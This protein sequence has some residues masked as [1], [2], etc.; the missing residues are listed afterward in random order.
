MKISGLPVDTLR[1]H[2]EDGYGLQELAYE[3]NSENMTEVLAGLRHRFGTPVGATIEVNRSYPQQQ[4]VWHA[5][6]DVITAVKSEV[7]PFLLYY[8]PSLLD[9]SIL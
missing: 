6:E 5:G 2:I 4:W 9:P 3:L 8:R 1:V 7:R